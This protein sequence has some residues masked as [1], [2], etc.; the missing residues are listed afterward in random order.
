MCCLFWEN[1]SCTATRP[2]YRS[3]TDVLKGNATNVVFIVVSSMSVLVNVICFGLHVFKQTKANKAYSIIVYSNNISNVVLCVFLTI[4]WASHL[5]IGGNFAFRNLLWR[6]GSVCFAAFGLH[7]FYTFSSQM[8]TTLMSFS[9]LMV[10]VHPF[11]S[12]LKRS[13]P[14]LKY[15]FVL[16]CAS[17]LVSLCFTLVMF[18]VFRTISTEMCVGLFDPTGQVVLV[19]CL[20]WTCFGVHVILCVAVVCMHTTLGVETFKSKTAAAASQQGQ[21]QSLILQLCLL[22]ASIVVCWL[23]VQ[24]ICVT[25]WH[26][27]VY[28]T[29]I[30]PWTLVL[31][32]PINSVVLPSVL[33]GF[34]IKSIVK[35]K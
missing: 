4:L 7:L 26:L 13:K 34:L 8:V 3:C 12:K 19:Q 1:V 21:S 14:V 32:Q 15:L 2:W 11:D 25:T 16:T 22:S 23:S 29:E 18:F 20:V 24:I 9:R 35:E 33:T 5:H 17:L 28:P 27:E 30:A 6:S 31:L 10:V